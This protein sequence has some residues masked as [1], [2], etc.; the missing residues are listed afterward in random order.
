RLSRDREFEARCYFNIAKCELNLA[1]SQD[2]M[3][4][5]Y[6]EYSWQTISLPKNMSFSTIEDRYSDT[7]FRARIRNHCSY[8]QLYINN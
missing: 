5:S 1:P 6:G 3:N 7:N 8:Y 2:R 4:I